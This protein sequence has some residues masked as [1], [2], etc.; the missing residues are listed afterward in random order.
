[1]L[2]LL[3]SSGA[4]YGLASTP[5]FTLAGTDLPELRWTMPGAVT[6]ALATPIGTNLFQLRTK[7]LEDRLRALPA[8]AEARVEVSLPDTIVVTIQEREAIVAWAVGD[9][10]F[11]V[12]RDGV[13]FA[14]LT[15]A[16][17]SAQKLPTIRDSRPAAAGLFVGASLDPVDLDAATRLASLTP[18][19][20]GSVAKSL[21]V[22]VT[23]ANGFVLVPVPRTWTAVFGLYTPTLRTPELIPG[24]VRLLRS[25][26]A[27]REDS[28][29]KVILADADSGTFIPKA[30]PAP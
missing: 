13:V 10:R 16:A 7:P 6:T 26:L 27:G 1:M 30:T 28:V 5:A 4:T 8:V 21:I 24:Q 18:G 22:T 23:E 15:A 20:I 14:N 29:A 12:D 2:G 17:A 9:S 11:L 3:A 19:D 25:L